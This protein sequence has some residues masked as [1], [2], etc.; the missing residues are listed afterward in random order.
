[1]SDRLARFDIHPSGPLWG[2]AE[3]ATQGAALELELRVAREFPE[4]AEL[5]SREGLQQERR[6]LR[7]AV[8]ELH[9]EFDAGTVTLTFRLGRGQF[10]TAVLREIFEIESMP[11][12]ESDED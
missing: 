8:H 10:A 2:R 6:P 1:M 12:L 9:A 11:I 5:L 3:P 7:S 4:V